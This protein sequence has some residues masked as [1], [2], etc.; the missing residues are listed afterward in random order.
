M[1]GVIVS[2][3]LV[4]IYRRKQIIFYRFHLLLQVQTE[5]QQISETQVVTTIPDADNINHIVVFLTGTMPFPGG[6][7]GQGIY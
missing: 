5:F 3:R 6:T 2:G 1:F 4:R 7:G